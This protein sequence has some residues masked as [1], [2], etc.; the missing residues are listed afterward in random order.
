MA[1]GRPWEADKENLLSVME[2]ETSF[3]LLQIPATEIQLTLSH[4]VT[5]RSVYF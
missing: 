4:F 2:S 5:L 3:P 1:K